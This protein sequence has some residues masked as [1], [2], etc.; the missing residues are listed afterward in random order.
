M[1]EASDRNLSRLSNN[2]ALARQSPQNQLE[3]GFKKLFMSIN[4]ELIMKVK[5]IKESYFDRSQ[6]KYVTDKPKTKAKSVIDKT[7]PPAELDRLKY[8]QARD[9]YEPEEFTHEK[10]GVREVEAVVLPRSIT[11]LWDP[12]GFDFY[13]F[14]EN[15]DLWFLQR[16]RKQGKDDGRIVDV[17]A[18]D[19][20]KYKGGRRA[21]IYFQVEAHDM[22]HNKKRPAGAKDP[23]GYGGPGWDLEYVE[24]QAGG[25]K[26][27]RLKLPYLKLAQ[28]ASSGGGSMPTQGKKVTDADWDKWTSG[29]KGGSARK[30]SP[31][32]KARWQAYNDQV[33]AAIEKTVN[34]VYRAAGASPTMTDDGVRLGDMYDFTEKTPQGRMTVWGR[35]AGGYAYSTDWEKFDPKKQIGAAQDYQKNDGGRGTIKKLVALLKELIED[36]V[37]A[38]G[39]AMKNRSRFDWQRVRDIQNQIDE[40]WLE[41]NNI[42]LSPDRQYVEV[43]DP[44]KRNLRESKRKVKIKIK[45]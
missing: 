15:L 5:I 4:E 36:G 10:S 19:G 30:S 37:H 29:N 38:T 23:G 11:E 12:E 8:V 18:E 44:P 22:S 3:N 17:K 20:S 13:P 39:I 28:P 43:I 25:R 2:V 42:G 40:A 16:R 41:L 45:K 34:R 1:A 7:R 24:E 31:Q 21:I 6:K 14:Y 26:L 27:W 9:P 32:E 33:E 35:R